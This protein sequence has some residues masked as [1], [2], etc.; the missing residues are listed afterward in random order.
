MP[1]EIHCLTTPQ[2][3]VE[4][5]TIDADAVLTKEGA[6]KNK[7]TGNR[8]DDIIGAG[9]GADQMKGGK[10]A[11][12]FYWGFDFS[13]SF[14]KKQAD[15][16]TD[17]KARQGDQILL[18]EDAFGG[19]GEM[20]TFSVAFNKKELRQAATFGADLIY[21]EAKGYLY[22]DQNQEEKGFGDGGGFRCFEQE[23]RTECCQYWFDG[24][25]SR[26][27]LDPPADENLQHLPMS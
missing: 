22:S 6:G 16:V 7:I 24:L 18:D 17:F 14:G 20:F 25:A 5:A 2:G 27:V 12:S 21:F 15:R 19:F 8:H 3:Q 10:G 11:D 4:E 9:S 26:H 23:A 1:T 13:V